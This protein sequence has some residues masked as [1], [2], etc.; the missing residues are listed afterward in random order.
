VERARLPL[1]FDLAF[2]RVGRTLLSAAIDLLLFLPLT[3]LFVFDLRGTT[4]ANT[5]VEERR[6]SAALSDYRN[7]IV[8]PSHFGAGETGECERGICF[9]LTCVT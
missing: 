2:A 1:A 3:L 9:L 8:T 4:A 6:F 5:T 7:N